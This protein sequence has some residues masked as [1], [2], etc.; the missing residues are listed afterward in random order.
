MK[1]TIS[2][3]IYTKCTDFAKDSVSSS[4]NKYAGR[5]Q[6]NVEKIIKDILCGKIGEEI[7]YSFLIEKFPSLTKPDYQ[8]YDS[9]NKSWDSDLKVIDSNIKIAV[10]SQNIDSSIH[11]GD[12]WVFQYNNNKNYD[13]DKEIFK[14]TNNDSYVTFVSLNIPKKQ[15]LIRAIVKVN[16]LHE[17][18]LFKEMKK[19]N[20]RGNKVAVYLEDLESYKD[21]LFQL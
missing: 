4:S 13:C 3:D 8:I 20:L 12:S 16:W 21:D 10:K 9:F 2:P 18:N 6:F 11:F 14:S 7:A 5:N 17:K 19:E 15:A 1:F